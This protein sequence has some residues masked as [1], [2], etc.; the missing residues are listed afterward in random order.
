LLSAAV[1][2]A[3]PSFDTSTAARRRLPSLSLGWVLGMMEKDEEEG[4]G[5]RQGVE[6]RGREK[7]E[8]KDPS[9]P[10]LYVFLILLM[11]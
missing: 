10:P 1:T 9:K 7:G 5:D 8:V 3:K 11:H 6:Q 2:A 4:Q